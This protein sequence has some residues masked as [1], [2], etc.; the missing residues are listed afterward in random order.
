MTGFEPTDRGKKIGLLPIITCFSGLVWNSSFL[1]LVHSFGASSIFSNM[2][3]PL[4]SYVYESMAKNAVPIFTIPHPFIDCEL[5]N[6]LALNSLFQWKLS[7]KACNVCPNYHRPC[8][9]ITFLLGF[10]FFFF[11]IILF[12]HFWLSYYINE[13]KSK[14]VWVSLPVRELF[15]KTVSLGQLGNRDF[16]S[17][18][19]FS[20]SVWVCIIGHVN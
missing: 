15:H 8:Y 5:I 7:C 4:L 20:L 17:W 18:F 12:I 16:K 2:C 13:D 6:W 19:M 1:F 14:I 11:L 9:G 10:F 3:M